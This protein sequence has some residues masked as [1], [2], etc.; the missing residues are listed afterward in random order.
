MAM[1]LNAGRPM[2][3]MVNAGAIAPTSP[4]PGDTTD[5]K[6]EHIREGL[7][8]FAGRELALDDEVYQSEA[9]TNQRNRALAEL[10]DSY[11]HIHFDPIAATDVYTRQCSLRVSTRD[12]AVMAATSADG[13]LNP[14]TG[15]Q[16]IAPL[17]CQYVLAALAAAGMYE[18]SGDW[19]FEI[20]VPAKSGVSGGIIAISP[21]KGALASY[22]PRLDHAGNSVRGQRATRYLSQTVGL[23]L[24]A[25]RPW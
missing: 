25:S 1:E 3:P 20:G 6:W 2:N 16:V 14:L 11:G 5:A 4:V 12:L 18:H 22:S 10:L 15:E 21:G 9:A 24:F 17:H 8:R 7:S 23:N 19:R 13:G